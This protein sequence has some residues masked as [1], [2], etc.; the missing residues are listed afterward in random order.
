MFLSYKQIEYA[1]GSVDNFLNDLIHRSAGCSWQADQDGIWFHFDFDTYIGNDNSGY[2][3]TDS[4]DIGFDTS[5]FGFISRSKKQIVN[6]YMNIM[7]K[8]KKHK[9]WC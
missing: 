3:T 1:Y 6:K 2:I 9:E 5:I 4:D 8:N 7:R